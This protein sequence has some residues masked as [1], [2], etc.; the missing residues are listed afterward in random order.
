MLAVAGR[1]VIGSLAEAAARRVYNGRVRRT[2]ERCVAMLVALAVAPGVAGAQVAAEREVERVMDGTGYVGLVLYQDRAAHFDD[3]MLGVAAGADI[4][5]LS[6]TFLFQKMGVDVGATVDDD[7]D[8]GVENAKPHVT[9]SGF[10]FRVDAMLGVAFGGAARYGWVAAGLGV[11]GDVRGA[12]PAA[13][14]APAEVGFIS[15]LTPSLRGQLWVRG[16]T[17]LAA[18]SSRVEGADGLFTDELQVGVRLI[19]TTENRTKAGED[20]ARGPS[21]GA[22]MHRTMGAAV[23]MIQVGIG[24]TS[25]Q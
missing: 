25:L 9:A 18:R 2:V 14:I 7:S 21:V 12:V 5:R 10:R 11:N 3:R 22:V 4:Q 19:L 16:D 13:V 6:H 15:R 8:A 1:S 24:A 20:L 17:F 23:W